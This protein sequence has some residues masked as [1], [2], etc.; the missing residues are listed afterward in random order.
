MKIIELLITLGNILSTKRECRIG[1]N[2][3][4]LFH[5]LLLCKQ[6]QITTLEACQQLWAPTSPIKIHV[7]LTT[8]IAQ[9]LY[10]DACLH[11]AQV[12]LGHNRCI[13]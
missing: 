8:E 1:A 12:R 3:T 9:T 5:S 11:Y 4:S 2:T 13:F 6:L 10:V 7:P